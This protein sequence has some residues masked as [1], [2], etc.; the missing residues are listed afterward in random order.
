MLFFRIFQHL[1]PDGAPWRPRDPGAPGQGFHLW[2]FLKGLAKGISGTDIPGGT[3]ARAYIDAVHADAFPATTRE[4]PEWQR[5]FGLRATGVT[6]TD[7]QQLAAAWAEEGGQSPSYIQG[8][9]QAAGFNVYVHDWW[10]TGPTPGDLNAPYVA[11]DPHDYTE[12]PLIGTNQCDA[13]TLT[14]PQCTGF[15]FDGTPQAGQPQCDRFLAN[16]PGYIVNQDFSQAAPPPIPD[17]P[18]TWPYFMYI[19]G[20]T[21]GTEAAV[22]P[23]RRAEFERLVLK[24]RP[25]HLWI[26]LLIDYSGG[27]FD[28]TFSP[29]FD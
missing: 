7:R 18:L 15:S 2:R 17:D 22:P 24:L 20:S 13:V 10:S 3:D 28:A 21:F 16:E 23:T 11:R 27:T 14:Q 26:V 1:L 5:Q 9:L 4:L 6:A 12:V 8:Q 19:G 29:A 25:L